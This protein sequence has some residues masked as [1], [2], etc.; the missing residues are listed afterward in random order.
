MKGLRRQL[1]LYLVV[2]TII[3]LA[4]LSAVSLEQWT[5]NQCSCGSPAHK[6]SS[7][8]LGRGGASA[9]ASVQRWCS[10]CAQACVTVRGWAAACVDVDTPAHAT[11]YL[12]TSLL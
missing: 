12:P 5:E 6:D 9:S 10:V 2:S 11:G 4:A 1:H 8:V 3:Y 7:Q